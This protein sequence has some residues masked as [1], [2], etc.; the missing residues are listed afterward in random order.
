MREGKFV[1]I[2]PPE[3]IF[4]LHVFRRGGEVACKF[5]E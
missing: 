2:P 3:D 5:I 4:V 1:F